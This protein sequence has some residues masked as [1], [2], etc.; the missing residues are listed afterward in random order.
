MASRE[1]KYHNHSYNINYE[2]LH[3]NQQQT[4]IILHGW[5]SNKEI[6]K[7]AFGKHFNSFRH[8]YIDMPGFGKSPNENILTTED[9]AAIMIALLQ[10]LSLEADIVFGHSYGGKVATLM[11]PKLLVLLSSAGIVIPKSFKVR[12]KIRLFK[13][14]KPLGLHS[15]RHFFA[16]KDVEGMNQGMYET[17]KNVID[18]D[19]SPHFK[20]FKNPTLLFWGKEDTATPLYTGEKMAALIENSH[21]YP[22]EGDHYFFLKEAD[23]IEEKI[24][25]ELHGTH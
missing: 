23:F 13:L 4:I 10:D 16:S 6:M 21:F 18:E 14:L 24:E 22:R 8:L 19:F 9:Y 7:Q 12:V 20:A 15:L 3:H 1:I 2:I 25:K 5:G 11:H 17:F